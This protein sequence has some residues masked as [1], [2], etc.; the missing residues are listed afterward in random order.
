MKLMETRG[1]CSR[2]LKR[3]AAHNTA[4][5]CEESRLGLD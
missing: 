2:R 3:A 5:V 4:I 1:V